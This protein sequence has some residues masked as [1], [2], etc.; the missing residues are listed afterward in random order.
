MARNPDSGTHAFVFAR[1]LDGAGGGSDIAEAH[2]TTETSWVHIDYSA[3]DTETKLGELGV[4]TATI[5][6][7]TRPDTRPRMV[8]TADGVMLVLRAVNLN[9][10][11]DPED[12]VSL[13][14]LIQAE[15]LVTVRQR[16]IFSVQDVKDSLDDGIGP[17]T[18]AEVVSTIIE[19]IAD[20]IADFVDRIEDEVE[21]Y[22]A[23]VKHEPLGRLRSR[24]A[25]SRREIAQV[26]RYLAPQRDALEALCREAPEWLAKQV[27][28]FREQSDRITRAVE[29]LDLARENALVLQEELSNRVAQEQNS[30]MYALSIVA[31]IFLPITFIT[32][33]FGMNVAGLP[34]TQNEAAFWIVSGAM[35][36]ASLGILVWLK[37]R[38]W[39]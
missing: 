20:R 17:R 8:R 26:R 34:G 15:R 19:R 37:V 28:E 32:G 13:R 23:G 18:V 33:F 25:E 4:A 14:L 7:L 31:V 36:V 3:P 22:E 38:H 9:P 35:L 24:V 29:D 2:V 21:G 5:E 12:M 6:A 10:G 30:R 39:L 27:H 1:Q 16:R 11:A